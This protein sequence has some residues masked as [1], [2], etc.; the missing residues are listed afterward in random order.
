MPQEQITDQP[1][2][3]PGRD[4]RTHI[5]KNK[6]TVKQPELEGTKLTIALHGQAQNPNILYEQR[7]T[8]NFQ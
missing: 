2:A 5:N 1:M 4:T 3:P 6:I 8:K 7:Q